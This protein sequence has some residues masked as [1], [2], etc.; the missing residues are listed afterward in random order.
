M[1]PPKLAAFCYILFMFKKRLTF[2]DFVER[3]NKVHNNKFDYSKAEFCNS[4]SKIKI[5]CTICN[6]SFFQTPRSHLSGNGCLFCAINNKTGSYDLFVE[7]ANKIHHY[8]YDYS[9][10]EYIKFGIKVKIICNI[11]GIFEQTP[12]SHLSGKGCP[13]CADEYTSSLLRKDNNLFIKQANEVHNSKYEYLDEYINRN[14]KIRI[15]CSIHGIFEQAPYHHLNGSGCPKCSTNYKKT[16]EEF[17]NLA[18]IA[19]NN[20]YIYFDDYINSTT[21]INI[22]C[23]KHG[24]FKQLP[25]VHL[26]GQG[27][28]TC[29]HIVSKCETEWLDSLGISI[30]QYKLQIGDCIIKVDGYDPITNTVYEFYG[31]YWHGNPNIYNRDDINNSCH[32][33]FGQLYDELIE[34]ENMLVNAGFNIVSIWESDWRIK[35]NQYIKL[36]A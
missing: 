12:N 35:N 9:K 13:K 22:Q 14:K 25:W 11:H 19:H 15:R 33:S 17:I 2:N 1:K 3:A 24:I 18:N 32:K 34:K 10:S 26:K 31:D 28:P 30:R 4:Y 20:K 23:L 36:H 16:K 5:V 21:H 8:K 7:K 6:K 29:A 27:C